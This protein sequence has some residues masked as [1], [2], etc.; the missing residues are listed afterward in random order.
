MIISKKDSRICIHEDHTDKVPRASYNFPTEKRPIYCKKH[1][2]EGMINLNNKNTSLCE[3]CKIKQPSYGII[4]GK[5]THCSKCSTNT[6]V[7]LVSN[8]C[9]D[10]TCRKN[11]TYGNIGEKATSCK[12]HALENMIDVKNTKCMCCSK[13][14]TYGINKPTHCINHKTDIMTDLKHTKVR[15]N[16]CD[17]RATYGKNGGKPSHCSVH[18]LE[19]MIDVC[20]RMCVK[21]KNTQSVFGTN[22]KDLYCKRCKNE[23]MKNVKAKMCEKCDERQPTFNY[24]GI[25]P[26]RFCCGCKLDGMIDVVNPMCKSCGLFMVTKKPNLCSYCKPKSTLREKTK[27]ML[28]VNYFE[29]NK[30]EFVHNK[31]VGFVC[32]NYRPDVRIDAGTHIV[33]VEIDE[34]QHSQYEDRCE[35]SRMLNIYQAE[36]MRCVF[37]RYNPDI[38]RVKGNAKKVHRPIRLG[39]L[40]E[41]V[42]KYMNSIPDDELTVYR[43]FYNND[44]G[45]YVEKYDIGSETMKY[46]NPKPPRRVE[47][48]DGFVIEYD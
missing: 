48:D 47:Y 40:L 27:E 26:P 16:D 39:L 13:Q 10:S 46:F 14:P 32:G 23:D 38:F 4:G 44:S 1:S 31:S 36:G 41:Y 30:I 19:D 11:A 22:K 2:T 25:K 42:N 18:K 20:S 43:L 9:S 6:M 5:A 35:I 29:E 7:D 33:V 12:K 37:I 21:C 15:C 45:E 24:K 28:V 17:I 8:L 34:N 3:D